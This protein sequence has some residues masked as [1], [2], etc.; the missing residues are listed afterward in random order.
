MRVL[1]DPIYKGSLIGLL[2]VSALA[3]QSS[4]GLLPKRSW[5]IGLFQPF[6][7]GFSDKI[8]YS[9]HPILFFVMPNLSIKVLHRKGKLFSS[10]TRYSVYYPTKLLKMLQ[11]G[12][13][14][15]DE[16]AS[17][18]AP[19][20]KIPHMVG[21][22]SDYI[23]TKPY[24][25]GIISI[26]GGVNAGVV[27]GDLDDRTSID[28]P[29]VYHRFGIFYNRYGIDMGI[30]FS[31]QITD[32]ISCDV[33]FDLKILPNFSGSYSFEHKILLSWKKSERVSFSTGYKYVYGEFPYGKKGRL[34]PYL[35]LI[36]SWV[37]IFDIQWVGL[38]KNRKIK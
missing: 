1:L 34:L 9:T 28:L 35:P 37:P 3:S 33:D 2:T 25:F 21:F 23:I 20:F 38:R 30:D 22:S 10:S 36:E 8:N 26:Y 6:R 24:G 7:Y 5:E 16:T 15:G 11:T 19:N 13:E 31:K 32:A 17:L 18:I 4:A 27:F 12:I 14:V 29:L